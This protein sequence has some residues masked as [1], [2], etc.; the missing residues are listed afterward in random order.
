VLPEVGVVAIVAALFLRL[1][2]RHAG[3][4]IAGVSAIAAFSIGAA[5][6][7]SFAWF[8]VGFLYGSEHYPYLFISSCYNLP[9]LMAHLD[10][11]LKTPFFAIDLGAFHLAFT[12]Q[13]TLRALYLLALILCARGAAG[14]ARRRDPRLLI[15]IAT[16]WLVMF[17]LLGQMHERY[18]LWGAVLSC[19]AF[20]VNA[21]LSLLHFLF[22]AMS[23]AM[24]TDVLLL[25]KKLSSTLHAIDLLEQ[26][27][28]L[29][30]WLLLAAVGVYF[31]QAISQRSPRRDRPRRVAPAPRATPLREFAAAGKEA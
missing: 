28:P 24:I 18:L 1:R 10:W 3:C 14:H 6:G 9:S 11:S 4:W 27:R 22:S 26:V 12:W 30:S 21:R 16:P 5:M 17:A 31:W 13:W 29:A 15:A 23:A 7:G 8:K 2:L 25:D 19:V 20:G